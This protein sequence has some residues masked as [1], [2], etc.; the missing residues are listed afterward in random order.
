VQLLQP[1]HGHT[2]V[3]SPFLAPGARVADSAPSPKPSNSMTSECQTF[4]ARMRTRTTP[5]AG[6]LNSSMTACI[7]SPWRTGLMQRQWQRQW[8]WQR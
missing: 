1:I 8:Q 7:G 6:G 2:T 4:A 3:L 5:A